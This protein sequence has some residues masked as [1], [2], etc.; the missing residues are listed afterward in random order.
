MAPGSEDPKNVSWAVRLSLIHVR[1]AGPEPVLLN[2]KSYV[3]R[4]PLLTF[5]LV[6]V[7]ANVKDGARTRAD[8]SAMSRTPFDSVAVTT[9]WYEPWARGGNRVNRNTFHADGLA[10]SVANRAIAAQ[11]AL[12]PPA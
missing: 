5:E 3:Y 9:A 1:P 7:L 10:R 8:A 11:F 4:S 6:V 2:H 12:R